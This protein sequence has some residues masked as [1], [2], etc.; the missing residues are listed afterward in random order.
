VTVW[1]MARPTIVGHLEVSGSVAAAFAGKEAR[2]A[3]IHLRRSGPS[4]IFI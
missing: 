3:Q 4:P 2:S 1:L